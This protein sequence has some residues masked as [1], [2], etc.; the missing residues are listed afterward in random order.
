MRQQALAMALRANMDAGLTEDVDHALQ[1]RL[2]EIQTGKHTEMHS[3]GMGTTG[4]G[5]NHGANPIYFIW[6]EL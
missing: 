4:H 1:Y 2:V 5:L 3:S 6:A